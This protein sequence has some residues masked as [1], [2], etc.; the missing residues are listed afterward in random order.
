MIKL[1]F[2]VFFYLVSFSALANLVDTIKSVKSA[3]VGIG[4]YKPL[5]SPRAQLKGTGFFIRDHLIVTNY[6][7]ISDDLNIQENEKRVIFVGEGNR[8]KLIDFSVLTYDAAHDL[9]LLKISTSNNLNITPLKLARGSQPAGTE[10][11]FTGFPIGAV[12]GLYPVTHRGIISAVTPVVTPAANA[13]Q[14]S[15]SALKR[16][17]KP[18]LTYQLDATAYPGNSGSPVYDQKTGKVLAVINKVFIKSSKE[19]ALTDPS[20]ITY[21]IPAEHLQNLLKKHSQL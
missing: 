16:L 6:H 11:A 10:I 14:L 18:F 4:T 3:V 19:S 9:A 13:N 17:K 1:A 15:I 5:G 8:P 20:G 12:L 21:A 2:V 7:L